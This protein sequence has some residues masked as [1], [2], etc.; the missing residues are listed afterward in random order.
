M[1]RRN[2]WPVCGRRAARNSVRTPAILTDSRG[3]FPNSLHINAEGVDGTML[4]I[5]YDSLSTM[6]ELLN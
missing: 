6:T 1:K 4:C 5:R 2:L 3:D